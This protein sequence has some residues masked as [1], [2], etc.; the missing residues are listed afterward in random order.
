MKTLAIVLIVS[1]SFAACNNNSTAIE[2]KVDSIKDKIDSTTHAKID[3]LKD[4]AD[5]LKNKV[6]ATFNK[7]DSAN[8]ANS[9][10]TKRH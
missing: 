4:S 7:T 10:S 1:V 6:E 8:L 2:Q 3:T 9:D 5:R